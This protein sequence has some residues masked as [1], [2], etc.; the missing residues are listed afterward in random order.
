VK[1]NSYVLLCMAFGCSPFLLDIYGFGDL[2][3]LVDKEKEV[4]VTMEKIY[5]KH[6]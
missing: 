2:E 3:Q 4:K 6:N 1:V 5:T